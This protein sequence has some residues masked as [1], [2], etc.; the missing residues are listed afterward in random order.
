ML[1]TAKTTKEMLPIKY[2][3]K[4]PQSCSN[5][6]NQKPL[7]ARTSL[8]F[9]YILLTFQNLTAPAKKTM[10][11]QNKLIMLYR[12]KYIYIF[13]DSDSG[14]TDKERDFTEIVVSLIKC[15][16]IYY[17]MQYCS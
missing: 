4:K 2:G 5:R 7:K 12:G 11:K 15:L 13:F 8:L 6:M 9:S 16:V 10:I 17:Q 1:P 14:V 3:R